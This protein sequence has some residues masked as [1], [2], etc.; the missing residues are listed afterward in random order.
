MVADRYLASSVAYGEA[1]GLD[2]DWLFEA[3]RYL[4]PPALTVMIDIAPATAV[5]RKQSNRDRFEQDLAMLERVRVSYRR[6]AAGAGL[7]G[8]RRRAGDRRG[9]GR[10]RPRGIDAARAAVSARTS[11]TPPAF[12]T[13]A[14]ASSVAPVV[15]RRPRA[16]RTRRAGAGRAARRRRKPRRGG[17]K[18]ACT[19]RRRRAALRPNC[20]AVARTRRSAWH[21]RQAQPA[22]ESSA[23]LNPRACRRRQCSGTGTTKSAPSS[24]S[25]PRSLIRA[26]SRPASV[27]RPS[28]LSAWRSWRST[29]S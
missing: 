1:Q 8:D 15:P 23:W 4:P 9:G 18:A 29:P 28:Y 26:L 5:A 22:R 21:D 24:T 10:R 3:Q 19:L 13:A 20:G 12:N 16:P 6:Q 11:R 17:A 25:R 2:P 27:R 14:H 7:G